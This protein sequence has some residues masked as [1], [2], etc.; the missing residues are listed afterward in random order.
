MLFTAEEETATTTTNTTLDESLERY[1][2]ELF[3]TMCTK[4]V[5]LEELNY[6]I[7][8]PSSNQVSFQT[9]ECR[10]PLWIKALHARYI[11][12]N[13]NNTNTTWHEQND[14]NKPSKCIKTTLEIKYKDQ[15][16][17]TINVHTSTGRIQIQGDLNLIKQWGSN[18]FPELFKVVNNNGDMPEN[19]NI[20]STFL[21]SIKN[22]DSKKS[23][24]IPDVKETS[25]KNE[26]YKESPREKSFS[27]IKEHLAALEADFVNLKEE[28]NKN[29]TLL[30]ERMDKKDDE[31]CLLKEEIELLKKL[32]KEKQQAISD[33][34]LKH[35]EIEGKLKKLSKTQT[36]HQKDTKNLISSLSKTKND[37]TLNNDNETTSSLPELAP[38]YSVPTSNTFEALSSTN[39]EDATMP[40]ENETHGTL[41]TIDESHADQPST[42]SPDTTTTIDA[43]S[44]IMCD[45]NGKFLN[46][47][48]L[49]PNTSTHYIRCPTLTTAQD[50]MKKHS[51][52]NTKSIII[53]CGTNDLEKIS[54][55]KELVKLYEDL[56]EKTQNKYP[57]CRVI[58]SG[59]LPRNDRLN[60]RVNRVNNK[61]KEVVSNK[62]NTS[63]VDHNNIGSH[64][65]RDKKHLHKTS[66]K[67]FARNIK[68]AFFKTSP[69]T[70]GRKNSQDP[71]PNKTSQRQRNPFIPPF[72]IPTHQNLPFNPPFGIPPVNPPKHLQPLLQQHPPLFR[73]PAMHSRQAG[74]PHA[75]EDKWYLTT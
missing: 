33:L 13:D 39:H 36:K 30:V 42:Q 16:A 64:D 43:E 61:V 35:L 45:S 67:L 49:C 68:G 17:L 51:F 7:Y 40:I 55:D 52:T 19:Y 63:Y 58:I 10:L 75:R 65:L 53:H 15:T 46:P 11:E 2:V 8:K 74:T 28:D 6:T 29:I 71:R 20:T 41:K 5:P 1:R 66:V 34:T 60:E 69:K 14:Q 37:P 12:P 31:I 50:I 73:S 23:T 4:H 9:S 21:E 44:I 59:L 62:E 27:M 38:T 3:K 25:I 56:L 54:S 22:K 32:N 26:S 47:T 72:N 18:E 48:L 57:D 70:K 24:P